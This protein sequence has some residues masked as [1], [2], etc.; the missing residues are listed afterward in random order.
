MK[1]ETNHLFDVMELRMHN[2]L[3]VLVRFAA[4]MKNIEALATC[5][6]KAIK[7]CVNIPAAAAGVVSG[8]RGTQYS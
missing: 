6:P 8:K 4:A 2:L 5:D 1:R 7:V 3:L